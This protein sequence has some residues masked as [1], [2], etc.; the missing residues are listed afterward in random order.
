MILGIC[1]II[2]AETTPNSDSNLN[3]KL[4]CIGILSVHLGLWP[5]CIACS[6]DI[7]RSMIAE[8]VMHHSKQV[9][10]VSITSFEHQENSA[11]PPYSDQYPRFCSQ[12]HVPRS[13]LTA[14]LCSSC[15]H[16]FDEY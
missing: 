16:S 7:G 3:S 8:G 15:G 6:I 2:V 14:K 13:D 10:P 11:P 12:C 5:P 1:F 9:A 4:L